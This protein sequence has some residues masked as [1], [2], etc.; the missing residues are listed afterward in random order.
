MNEPN[1]KQSLPRDSSVPIL[2][3]NRSVQPHSTTLELLLC[4]QD[5][6]RVVFFELL[7]T[8]PYENREILSILRSCDKGLSYILKQRRIAR[9]FVC[10]LF[11]HT[12][13]RFLSYSA[14][15]LINWVHRFFVVNCLLRFSSE[16]SLGLSWKAKTQKYQMTSNDHIWSNSLFIWGDVRWSAIGTYR[17]IMST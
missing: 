13:S 9:T 1:L 15:D 2:S 12:K 7:S 4:T 16:P 11:M 10:R 17:N 14:G 5:P 8:S 3:R 6:T